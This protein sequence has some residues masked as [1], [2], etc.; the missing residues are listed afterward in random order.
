MR[1][2]GD[3]VHPQLQ[4]VSDGFTCK[5]SSLAGNGRVVSTSLLNMNLRGLTRS[6]NSDCRVELLKPE[7]AEKQ[8]RDVESLQNTGAGGEKMPVLCFGPKSAMGHILVRV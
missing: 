3:F 5:L 1:G 8:T 7:T 6:A 4:S 2:D